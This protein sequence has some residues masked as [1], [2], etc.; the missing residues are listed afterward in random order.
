MARV[1]KIAR[2]PEAVREEVCRRLQSGQLGPQILPWLNALPEVKSVLSEFF[3][4]SAVNAQ[5]LSDWRSGGFREWLD[6]RD[7]VHQTRELASYS[8]KL[9]QAA[10]GKI[11]EGA[12][13]MLAGQLLE[14]ME[15][16]RDLREKAEGRRQNEEGSAERLAGIAKA[17]DSVSRAIAS[18]RRGDHDAA[19]LEQNARRLA[20]KDKDI[21]LAQA[22]FDQKLREYQD[23]VAAQKREIESAL[24]TA[25]SGGLTPDTLQRIEEAARLL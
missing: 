15:G 12:S 17:V 2:L 24:T 22:A 20:Q 19:V 7:R 3:D 23:K 18:V 5:N 16:L 4:G 14:I 6:K 8:I 11:S 13:A 1:G 25:R 21:A 10:G 9:A